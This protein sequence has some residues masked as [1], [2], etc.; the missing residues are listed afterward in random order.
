MIERPI[1]AFKISVV[2]LQCTMCGA[3]TGAV[4]RC[5]AIYRPKAQRAAEAVAANPE[6]SN[7][8]L[9]SET[10]LSEATVRRARDATASD[11]AVYEP[12][13]GLDGKARK[14]PSFIP[15]PPPPIRDEL[16]EEAM[17]M[18]RQMTPPERVE[19]IKRVGR[20]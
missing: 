8:A 5:N 4:C 7:R 12:R 10:G 11:D 2:Q 19:F 13:I 18:V 17:E 14:L 15:D 20:L 6:K 16:I 1:P 3:E 9:A